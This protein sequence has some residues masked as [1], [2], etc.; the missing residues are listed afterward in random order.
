MA[1]T[2][3]QKRQI[4]SL[5]AEGWTL[6]AIST[7]TVAALKC[8]IAVKYDMMVERDLGACL[9]VLPAFERRLDACIRAGGWHFEKS[10]HVAPASSSVTPP[11]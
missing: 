3:A 11:S 7:E 8:E 5:L 9:E 2:G 6:E 1:L 4:A 10:D